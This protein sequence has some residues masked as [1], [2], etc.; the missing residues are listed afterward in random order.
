MWTTRTINGKR[1]YFKGWKIEGRTASKLEKPKK[2]AEGMDKGFIGRHRYQIV[3]FATD[4]AYIKTL[5][6]MSSKPRKK[7]KRKLIQG[8]T[9]KKKRASCRS[10]TR[11]GMMNE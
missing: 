9:C 6:R 10:W 8:M 5:P 7:N 11:L 1:Y 3:R 4:K 2:F